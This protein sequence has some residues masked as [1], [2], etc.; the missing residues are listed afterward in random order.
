[1]GTLKTLLGREDFRRRPVRALVKR[2][3]WRLRWRVKDAPWVLGLD[4]ELSA[5]VPH[6]GA[7]ALIYYQGSSSPGLAALIRRVLRPGMTFFDVG[8][9]LGE[10][11]L[12]AARRVQPGGQVHAFEANPE[13][14]DLLARNVRLNALQDVHIASTAVADRDG[15]VEFELGVET[16]MSSLRASSAPTPAPQVARHMRVPAVSLDTY[17]SGIG[18]NVDLVKIDVEGAEEKVLLGA[19]RLLALPDPS[20]PM[21]VLEVS[22]R[23]YERFGT[24]PAHV[25]GLLHDYGYALH[26]LDRDGSL[27]PLGP[28]AEVRGTIDV[29]AVKGR[30]VP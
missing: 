10:F 23:N 7:G 2:V 27:R 26:R 14:A 8:A 19:R 11:T 28:P 9:H 3:A 6:S 29:V 4:D 21:L 20:A 16:A 15:E 24:T 5:A 25:F 1:M 22:G 12:R 17:Q 30:V 18:R 13:L